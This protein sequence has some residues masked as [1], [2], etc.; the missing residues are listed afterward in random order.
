MGVHYLQRRGQ[1]RVR[2]GGNGAAG[3]VASAP[4]TPGLCGRR[5]GARAS[6]RRAAGGRGSLGQQKGWGGPEKVALPRPGPGGP[7]T[8]PARTA[9]PAR[10]HLAAGALATHLAER[11]AATAPAGS[12]EKSCRGRRERARRPLG[13][14]FAAAEARAGLSALPGS[15]VL[16]DSPPGLKPPRGAETVGRA[17]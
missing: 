13:S 8:A 15:R 4:S 10:P 12:P 9:G 1:S 5:E 6:G 16:R 3:A 14:F 2:D 7:R 17:D 11:G